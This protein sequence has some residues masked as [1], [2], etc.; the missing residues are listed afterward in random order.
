VFTTTFTSCKKDNTA[1]S[2][3]QT[4]QVYNNYTLDGEAAKAK[5]AKL[6][7][8]FKE[9]NS[10][11]RDASANIPLAEAVWNI[12]AV[13]NATYGHAYF[14]RQILKVFKDSI[15][16][17]TTDENGIKVVSS[18]VQSQKYTQVVDSILSKGNTFNFPVNK[19]SM[20]FT[21]VNA[22]TDSMGVLKLEINIGI[23]L[24]PKDCPTCPIGILTEIPN[25]DDANCWRYGY[26]QGTC[27]T[28]N[29][30]FGFGKKDATDVLEYWLNGLA[31]GSVLCLSAINP[32]NDG[33]YLNFDNSIKLDPFQNASLLTINPPHSTSKE[34]YK[35]RLFRTK[36]V[37]ERCIPVADMQFF[38]TQ[39]E[40]I[41]INK[42]GLVTTSDKVFVDCDFE[43]DILLSV[44]DVPFHHLK[45][46]YATFVPR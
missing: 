35:Y 1:P 19:R 45:Y 24:D 32:Y 46:R 31:N 40:Y 34:Y 18:I 2:T 29:T 21:D 5:I 33:F 11:S 4:N 44:V 3:S 30:S 13:A 43:S 42:I 16:I 36:V 22:V 39:G 26:K 28:P 9:V 25:C 15:L 14:K 38:R 20:I 41:I 12:E 8:D 37:N 27:N 17:P 6:Q 7:A 23:G 10:K